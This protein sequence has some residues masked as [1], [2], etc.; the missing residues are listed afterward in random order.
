[1]SMNNKLKDQALEICIEIFKCHPNPKISDLSTSIIRAWKVGKRA[2]L[3]NN[4]A[5]EDG[6]AKDCISGGECYEGKYCQCA[7]CDQYTCFN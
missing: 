2:C 5:V 7:G 4:K 3:L 1:M 6:Q